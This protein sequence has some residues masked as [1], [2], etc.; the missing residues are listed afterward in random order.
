MG[1][2]TLYSAS[3]GTDVVSTPA[4]ILPVSELSALFYTQVAPIRFYPSV[5][6]HEDAVEVSITDNRAL[7]INGQRVEISSGRS[8]FAWNTVMAL[9]DTEGISRADSHALGL[10]AF[11]ADRSYTG[12]TW[13][14]GSQQL[15]EHVNDAAGTPLL[16]RTAGKARHSSRFHV[17]PRLHIIDRRPVNP[18]SPDNFEQTL[19]TRLLALQNPQRL[20][21]PYGP[22][23]Q[24]LTITTNRQV[25]RDGE[26]WILSS[27]EIHLLNVIRLAGGRPLL[28][29]EVLRTGFMANAA[30][31]NSRNNGVR[32]AAEGL[33]RT[34]FGEHG[35]R[36]ALVLD[37]TDPVLLRLTRGVLISDARRMRTPEGG[38]TTDEILFAGMRRVLDEYRRDQTG[39]IAYEYP[40]VKHV[41]VPS[42]EQI[43]LGRRHAATA[44]LR[45]RI[46]LRDLYMVSLRQGLSIPFLHDTVLPLPDGNRVAYRD[47]EQHVY[48]GPLPMPEVGKLLGLNPTFYN[49][50]YRRV[51]R[52]VTEAVPQ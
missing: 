45:Q 17:D 50:L 20:D 41:K 36:P 16:Y 34:V 46:G 32:F 26:A 35:V 4:G 27:N 14:T 42:P 7:D 51:M 30:H 11:D 19:P 43:S 37:Y 47:L 10:L 49:Q 38:R 33:N 52:K 2:Y 39:R 21:V 40:P 22:G 13:Y 3:E 29:P 9:R 5:P 6:R 8:L 12:D 28:V 24:Q 25:E 31:Y 44:F 1:Q 23:A 15:M 18:A 48:S